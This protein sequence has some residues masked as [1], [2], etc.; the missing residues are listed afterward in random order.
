MEQMKKGRHSLIILSILMGFLTLMSSCVD[1]SGRAGRAIIQRFGTAE[2]V[3]T[4]CQNTFNISERACINS[5]PTG[6]RVANATEIEEAKTELEGL[7]L[8][9]ADFTDIISN[10]DSAL[11]VCVLGSGVLRPDNEVFID[12]GFCACQAGKPVS[13][14]DCQATCQNKTQNNMVLFGKVTVGP[15]IGFNDTLKNLEGWCNNEIPGTDFTG[16]ACQLEVFD[17]DS[18]QFLTINT[19]GNSFNVAVDS[20]QKERTYLA[21]I[22]ESQSGSNVQSQAFQFYLKDFEDES[23]TPEGPLK[24]M[25]VSQY[26][27]IFFARQNEPV[28]SFTEYARKHFYFASSNSPPSLPPSQPLTK[29]HDKQIFGEND[30]PLFPRLELIPQHFAVWDQTDIRFNDGDIDG[31]ID[32]N[33]EVTEE[34]RIKT[35]NTTAQLNL[36]TVFEWPNLPDTS[37]TPSGTSAN[38]GFIMIPFVDQNNRGECPTQEDYL[39]NNPLYEVIG[40][41]VGVDTEGLFMAESEPFLDAAGNAILDILMIRENELKQVWFYF[42]N[43]QH[44]VPDEVTAGSKTVRFYWPLDKNAPYIRKSNQIIYTVRFPSEI[45]RNGVQTGIIEGVRPPDNRFACIPAVD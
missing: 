5:C 1:E 40:D 18:T 12:K 35:G 20:L 28:V 42:E 13:I 39:S 9:A 22:R 45:G 30:S 43:G 27:C 21:R 15:N 38:L 33:A 25:P 24:V 34:F 11:E 14:N 23:T 36:F 44:F 2:E 4:F 29:C 31:V 16:P 7:N 6:T 26:T 19:V 41:K 10:I 17:G 3:P 37:S 8:D 32:I